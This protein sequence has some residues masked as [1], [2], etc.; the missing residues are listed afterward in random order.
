MTQSASVRWSPHWLLDEL[1]DGTLVVSA[2][3]DHRLALRGIDEA[4]SRAV[5]SWITDGPG[6]D[7]SAEERRLADR[8]TQAGVLEPSSP[9]VSRVHVIG[10]EPFA[11]KLLTAMEATADAD[12]FALVVRTGTEWPDAPGRHHLAIDCSNHHT[13]VLGPYVVPGLS[14][15]IECLQTRLAR[16]WEAV[17]AAPEPGVGRYLAVIAQLAAIQLELIERGSSPLVNATMTWDLETGDT[18]RAPLLKVPGCPRCDLA[19]PS[20]RL[21]LPWQPA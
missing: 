6:A 3:Q 5:R 20:G 4:T 11:T 10:S 17:P 13:L 1:P 14:S 18:E 9:A 12:G 15:C 21:Q 16:R 2:G 7:L 8:L 19:V